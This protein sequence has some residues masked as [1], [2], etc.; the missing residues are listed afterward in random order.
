MNNVDVRWCVNSNTNLNSTS[1]CTKLILMRVLFVIISL[2][3]HVC[4][5][6]GVW[7]FCVCGTAVF[8][9]SPFSHEM[10]DVNSCAI[11]CHTV[12]VQLEFHVKVPLERTVTCKPV[13]SNR[14][15]S[16]GFLFD[17]NLQSGACGAQ[18]RSEFFLFSD[19]FRYSLASS[20]YR[21]H[22]CR[23]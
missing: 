1:H 6:D 9:S 15:A 11:L 2:E 8:E 4:V 19:V 10:L 23:S 12:H 5:F 13:K 3:T 18:Q 14:V 20:Q 7:E 17:E 22:C 16:T 21:R